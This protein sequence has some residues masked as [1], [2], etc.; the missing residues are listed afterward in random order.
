M[1]YLLIFLCLAL[2]ASTVPSTEP[3]SEAEESRFPYYIA[4]ITGAVGQALSIVTATIGH[5]AIRSRVPRIESS[6]CYTFVAQPLLIYQLSET[7]SPLWQTPQEALESVVLGSL[8]NTQSTNEGH[9]RG[10]QLVSY[11]YYIWHF[12]TAIKRFFQ[13]NVFN[14]LSGVMVQTENNP[15]R[16]D[17]TA[18]TAAEPNVV[19]PDEIR[20]EHQAAQL[21]KWDLVKALVDKGVDPSQTFSYSVVMDRV[22]RHHEVAA[23]RLEGNEAPQST[24]QDLS[25][26]TVEHVVAVEPSVHDLLTKPGKLS[27]HLTPLILA[28]EVL[29]ERLQRI[30]LSKD[31]SHESLSTLNLKQLTEIHQTFK[32]VYD[33]QASSSKLRLVKNLLL[34]PDFR[35]VEGCLSS[36]MRSV[37]VVKESKINP[38]VFRA[39]ESFDF[40]LVRELLNS[41]A[42]PNQTFPSTHPDY[43]GLS[44]L[45]IAIQRTD[46]GL[47][48]DL[49]DKGANP[50]QTFPSTHR[51]YPGLSLVQA[52]ATAGKWDLV[53]ALLAKGA[54]YLGLSLLQVA[55]QWSNWDLVSELLDKG[56]DPNQTFPSTSKKFSNLSLLQAAA[57]ID[58][59]DLVIDLL[60]KGANPNQNFPSTLSAYLDLSLL[61]V[62]TQSSNWDLVKALL[63]N[64][65][66]L[67][68]P[69]PSTHRAYPG[70]SLLQVAAQ[71]SNWDLVKLLIDKGAD[72]NQA[73]PSTHIY[74]PGL[75]LLEVV[76]ELKEFNLVKVLVDKGADPNHTFPSTHRYY[77]G[78]SLL[79]VAAQSSKWD[80]AIHLVDKVANPNQTFPSTHRDYPGLSLVQIAAQLL[81]WDLVGVLAGKGVDLN[82]AFPSTH[83]YYPG[84]SLLQVATIRA[85]RDLVK[86]LVEKGAK[87]SLWPF[88][89]T[90]EQSFIAPEPLELKPLTTEER[91]KVGMGE[92]DFG[93]RESV[94]ALVSNIFPDSDEVITLPDVPNMSFTIQQF[95]AGAAVNDWYTGGV[96][97]FL[98]SVSDRMPIPGAPNRDT[99]PEEFNRFY[100]VM[101][102]RLQRIMVLLH[103]EKI[104]HSLKQAALINLFEGTLYCG[105]RRFQETGI[106]L[107]LLDPETGNNLSG[108]HSKVQN[109]LYEQRV[110]AFQKALPDGN[111]HTYNAYM[112]ELGESYGVA[113]PGANYPDPLGGSVDSAQFKKDFEENYNSRTIAERLYASARNPSEIAPSVI[114][115]LLADMAPRFSKANELSLLKAKIRF[116]AE[117]Q[118]RLRSLTDRRQQVSQVKQRAG[119]NKNEDFPESLK[120]PLTKSEEDELELL[121]ARD[122]KSGEELA[123]MKELAHRSQVVEVLALQLTEAENKALLALERR[124]TRGEMTDA[125]FAQYE[126]LLKEKDEEIEQ[127]MEAV[128][129]GSGFPTKD[130]VICV[131]LG[132]RVFKPKVYSG[133]YAGL[134]FPPLVQRWI[135]QRKSELSMAEPGSDRH[136]AISEWLNF[137]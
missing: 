108:A 16:E 38:Q 21:Q 96:W 35:S 76:V 7:L 99:A 74:Y 9:L 28:P 57:L 2:N 71:Q 89:R 37:Q 122:E 73:F 45:Q 14:Q 83:R 55:A 105:T 60:E 88:I 94:H 106:A 117:E 90:N 31:A 46:R 66:D 30:Y 8:N 1:R 100:D 24:S 20:P 126:T 109:L 69:F 25:D 130:G 135:E 44:L 82:Q 50:N 27:E 93:I 115:E 124:S 121:F 133:V 72:L 101:F 26:S 65:A 119:V 56:A 63:D 84:L 87:L 53:E 134:S 51:D 80:L 131:L 6:A 75:S 95:F 77:P 32:K 107:A 18:P 42:D 62:A 22:G 111:V 136:K 64:G 5:Q 104:E 120:R 97:P 125:E 58:K 10:K 67:N 19:P 110:H 43:P 114:P 61:Q 13:W 4:F 103:D 52:A 92:K 33:R 127:F 118:D 48:Q 128:L 123:K 40:D 12:G 29:L 3:A 41:G 85:R 81:D 15:M 86:I 59:L 68:Q 47:I 132:L 102:N 70:L 49:L 11:S 54:D 17:P 113:L 34:K 116:S 78:L 129:D 23:E 79:Q 91:A 39:F 98:Q 137:R 36:L 112:K